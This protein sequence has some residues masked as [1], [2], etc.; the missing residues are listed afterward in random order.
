MC[1]ATQGLYSIGAHGTLIKRLN[2]VLRMVLF[3]GRKHE[4]HHSQLLAFLQYN[5]GDLLKPA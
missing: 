1:R 2:G 5:D 4:N 3:M